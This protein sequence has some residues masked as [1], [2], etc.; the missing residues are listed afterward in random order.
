MFI[1]RTDVEAETP[2]LWQPDAKSW[3]IW[4]DPDAGKDW[5]Q[6]KGATEDEMV[7]WHHQL[8]GHEF[9]WTPRVGDG[10][11]GLASCGSWCHKESDTTEWLNWNFHSPLSLSSR[12]S[13]VLPHCHKGRGCHNSLQFLNFYF[14]FFPYYSFLPSL[15]SFSFPLFFLAFSSCFLFLPFP[16]TLSDYISLWKDLIFWIDSIIYLKIHVI[17]NWKCLITFKILNKITPGKAH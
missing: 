10:Q 13:L 14:L 9:E 2:I 12:G 1:G 8:N 6:E 15:L 11:G 5:R 17:R 3:L 7:G 16:E 4:K